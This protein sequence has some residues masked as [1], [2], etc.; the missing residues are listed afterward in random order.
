MKVFLTLIGI[1][2]TST[3]VFLGVGA[4]EYAKEPLVTDTCRNAASHQFMIHDDSWKKLPECSYLTTWEQDF[5]EH[6]LFPSRNKGVVS[7]G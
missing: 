4:H 7:N 2:V 1:V 3:A 5:V 6:L